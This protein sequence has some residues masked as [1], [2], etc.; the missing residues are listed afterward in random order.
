MFGV[1][2]N[3]H[4]KDFKQLLHHPKSAVVGLLSQFLVLPAITFL[5]VYLIRPMPSIALGM[6]MVAACPGGNVSNF[7]NHLAKGNNALSVSL[8]AFSSVAAIVMTPFSLELWAGMYAPTAGIL[9]QVNLDTLNILMTIGLILGLPLIAGMAVN[10]Y[11][12]RLARLLTS[13]LKPL[14][15]IIFVAFVIIAFINNVDTFLDY[16]HVV[17]LIVFIHNLAALGA[18]W[19]LGYLTRLSSRDRKTLAIETGIQNS[20]LGLILIFTFFDGLGGM[21]LV[22]AW[23]GIWH[24]IAG[25]LLASFWSVRASV[26]TAT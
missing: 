25:L 17:I 16:I 8:T 3:M 4:S 5:L 2:L 24:I 21:A 12:P 15:I 9:T 10:V 7:I 19:G 11:R 13:W 18:G 20:G 22:A 26:Q 6:M 23:W 14:S 1:A